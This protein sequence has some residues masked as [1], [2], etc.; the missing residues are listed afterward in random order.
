[1]SDVIR[2]GVIVKDRADP[3]DSECEEA[4]SDQ[5]EGGGMPARDESEQGQ[6]EAGREGSQDPRPGNFVG[7]PEYDTAD[8]KKKKNGKGTLDH[9]F[10]LPWAAGFVRDWLIAH[11]Q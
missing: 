11:S 2:C 8:E 1:V 10:T 3:V 5:A 4:D 6:D 7:V 9:T